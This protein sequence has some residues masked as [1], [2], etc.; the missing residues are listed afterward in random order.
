[1]GTTVDAG[2]RS[3]EAHLIMEL[4]YES[5]LVLIRPDQIVAW[6]RLPGSAIDA[7]AIFARATGGTVAV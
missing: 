4:L 5:D 6:R 1:V 7:S 3:S 2:V